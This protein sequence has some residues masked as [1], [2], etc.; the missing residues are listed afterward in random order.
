MPDIANDAFTGPQFEAA[1]RQ[2]TQR[3]YAGATSTGS[4]MIDGRERDDIIDTGT[5]IIIVEATRLPKRDKTEYDL[6]KSKA[7]VASLKRMSRFSEYNFRILLVT[8]NE[9]TADQNGVVSTTLTGCPKEIISFSTLFSRLFD[10]RHYLRLRHDHFFGSIRNPADDTDFD[11]PPSSYIPTALNEATTGIDRTASFLAS[12]A[13]HGGCFVIFGD[14]GSGKS[15]T[16]RDVYLKSK[17][18]FIR[19]ETITCPVYINLREHIAQ[20]QPDEVLFRHAQIIGFENYH[21]LISAW[22]SGYVN[23]FLDGFDELTPPQF[24]VTIS[25]LKQARRFAVELVK[26]F[27]E[28]SPRNASI[29]IAGRESYFDSRDEA[30]TA[31][32]YNNKANVYILSGF[33]D[34]Q[35]ASYLKAK[36]TSIPHWLP[37]RPLLLGYLANSGLI[38]DQGDLRE[39][40]ATIGWDIMLNR[41]CER[42]VAQIWGVGVDPAAL[43]L[44]IDGLASKARQHGGADSE[45]QDSDLRSV[46]LEVFGRDA[47]EPA[48]LL[49]SRL[50]GLGA[51][52]GRTGARSFIDVD[53]FDAATS[54]DMCRFIDAPYGSHPNLENAKSSLGHLALAMASEKTEAVNVS[55]ALLNASKKTSLSITASDLIAILIDK[56]H[57]YVGDSIIISDANFDNISIDSRLNFRNIEFRECTFMHVE[58]GR[59]TPDEEIANLPRFRRCAIDKLEGAVSDKDIP[60]KV[61]DVETTVENYV[62][63]SATNSAVME[64]NLPLPVRVLIVVLRKLFLQRGSGRQKAALRRGLSPTASPYVDQVLALICSHGFAEEMTIDRR[65]MV[66]PNRSRTGQAISII[67][68]PNTSNDLLIEQVRKI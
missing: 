66:I 67:N 36:R 50:P 14:Y 13:K 37:N 39:F 45:L 56:D 61:M 28:Q 29:Y 42:E 22:R 62:A 41:I 8:Q 68:S 57:G 52:P 5:E 53:F 58:I 3:L 11:V 47:D 60:H 51:V 24:A 15:M 6:A 33:T 2:V 59:S 16:L 18:R 12:S 25:N 21:S 20:T 26:R 7:L 40:P 44:F 32:G 23:L 27:V 63:F 55:I 4:I 54:G 19:G 1:V 17:D 65:Q 49:T 10:A 64:A 31:L 46:F 35:I 43:R 9:P 30:K 38:S 48:S 34:S